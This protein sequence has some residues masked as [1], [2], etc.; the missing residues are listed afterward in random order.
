M[1]VMTAGWLRF[2]PIKYS[3]SGCA[4]GAA[5]LPDCFRRIFLT[6]H[7]FLVVRSIALKTAAKAPLPRHLPNLNLD[8]GLEARAVTMELLVVDIMLVVG[9]FCVG[10]GVGVSVCRSV[11]WVWVCL[12]RSVCWK[13]FRHLDI[14]T[15]VWNLRKPEKPQNPQKLK[16]R[17]S[18]R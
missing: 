4:T 5:D 12:V 15:I 1:V 10:V 18:S 17:R 16:F 14:Y 11:C 8:S 7:S 2:L 9:G 13:K 6:A 3:R